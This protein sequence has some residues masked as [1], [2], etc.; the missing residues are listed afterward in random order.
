MSSRPGPSGEPRSY[1]AVVSARKASRFRNVW[2]EIAVVPQHVS[3]FERCAK[4]TRD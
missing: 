3:I 1:V 4:R 2:R